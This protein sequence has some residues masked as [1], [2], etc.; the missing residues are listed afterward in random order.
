M[1]VYMSHLHYCKNKNLYHGGPG[2]AA[3]GQVVDIKYE[4]RALAEL[5]LG[6]DAHRVTV[7]VGRVL[8]GIVSFDDHLTVLDES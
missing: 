5:G 7:A 2:T 4:E 3:C 8:G 6:G 1:S